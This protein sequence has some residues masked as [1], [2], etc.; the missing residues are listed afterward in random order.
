MSMWRAGPWG[1]HTASLTQPGSS[2]DA[3]T[4]DSLSEEGKLFFFLG[5]LKQPAE[6]NLVRARQAA[7]LEGSPVTSSLAIIWPIRQAPRTELGG[8]SFTVRSASAPAVL[9][10]FDPYQGMASQ[11]ILM[12]G[13]LGRP[14]NSKQDESAAAHIDGEARRDAQF[15]IATTIR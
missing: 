6:K 14:S 13:S 5:R 1:Q 12:R 3:L 9:S 8:Q 7:T 10:T 4:R 11:K 2:L 15:L